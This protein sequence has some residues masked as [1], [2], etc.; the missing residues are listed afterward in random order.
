MS[1]WVAAGAFSNVHMPHAHGDGAEEELEDDEE[2]EE[3]AAAE[4]PG[5]GESA[6]ARPPG[7]PASPALPG[8]APGPG[9]PAST[10]CVGPWQRDEV[11]TRQ[12]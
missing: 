5:R 10:W 9:E 7:M 2:E 12:S 8:P 6:P 11:Y 3:K 1:H 4:A